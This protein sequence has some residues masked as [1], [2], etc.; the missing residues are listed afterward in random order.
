MKPSKEP[1]AVPSPDRTRAVEVTAGMRI[2]RR[3]IFQARV[4]QEGAWPREMVDRIAVAKTLGFTAFE[5]DVTSVKAKHA[6]EK[7]VKADYITRMYFSVIESTVVEG[8]EWKG[9]KEKKA[10]RDDFVVTVYALVVE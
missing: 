6:E 7:V 10:L 9:D 1:L 2:T 5:I 4:G 3:P 8:E